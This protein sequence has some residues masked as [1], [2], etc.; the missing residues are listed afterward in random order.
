V[1]ACPSGEALARALIPAGRTSQVDCFVSA[2]GFYW[3]A[4]A[5]HHEAKGPAEPR[6]VLASGGL[7]DRVV[8]YDVEPAPIA[9]L[10]DL[11]GRSEQVAV[12]VRPAGGHQRKLVLFGV[13]GRR[14]GAA[15]PE[16]EEVLLLL[17]LVA[18]KP[19]RLLWTGP[20]DQATL[21]PDGCL[22]ERTIDFQMLFST[23]EMVTTHR[24]RRPGAGGPSGCPAPQS[25]QESLA[26]RPV[27]LRSPRTIDFRSGR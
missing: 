19:P 10:T 1:T 5:L 25:M 7:G 6:L 26:P 8:V 18:H 21:G 2:G 15:R 12:R 4:G 9:A 24:A 20:G 16:S 23:V 27:A 17:E 22:S 14:G 3:M 13:V 11:M